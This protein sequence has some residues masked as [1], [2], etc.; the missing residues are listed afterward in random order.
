MPDFLSGSGNLK[1]KIEITTPLEDRQRLH[2]NF[3]S[4]NVTLRNP[5][6]VIAD[7]LKKTNGYEYKT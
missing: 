4:K 3:F 6:G 5:C 2:D 7:G 1:A